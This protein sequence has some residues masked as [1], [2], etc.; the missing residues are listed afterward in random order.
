MTT[1]HS[2]GL[3]FN[4]LINIRRILVTSPGRIRI[5]GIGIRETL[6]GHSDANSNGNRR[7]SNALRQQQ[8]DDLYHLGWLLLVLTASPT[9]MSSSIRSPLNIHARDGGIGYTASQSTSTDTTIEHTVDPTFRLAVRAVV[10]S[11]RYSNELIQFIVFLLTSS[12]LPLDHPSAPNTFMVSAMI[13][14]RLSQQLT[15]AHSHIDS[16]EEDLYKEIQ[17]GRL[18]RLLL[19]LNFILER[20]E[21]RGDPR[22]SETGDRYLITLFRDLVFHSSIA[23]GTPNLDLAY[24]FS[25]L[26]RLDLA[27]DEKTLLSSRDGESALIV[28]FSDLHRAVD[29]AFTELGGGALPSTSLL[30]QKDYSTVDLSESGAP[31]SSSNLPTASA[32]VPYS[33]T[34]AYY[35]AG[36]GVASGL[37]TGHY[38]TSPHHN[39]SQSSLYTGLPT[40]QYDTVYTYP[41]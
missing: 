26:N 35:G 2:A 19:K 33:S 15:I 1:V 10:N 14:S 6:T 30:T 41:M 23:P 3:S 13:S 9:T 24:V 8:L 25:L 38:M 18:L 7:P 34:N 39:Q 20:P 36:A 31:T 16:V 4:G 28:K 5:N 40:N 17:N 29:E 21:Y 12:R 11:R 27:S 32:S 37:F 22:W